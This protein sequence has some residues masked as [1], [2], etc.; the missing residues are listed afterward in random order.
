MELPISGNQTIQI[1]GNFQFPEN[2]NALFGLVILDP[3]STSPGLA[4]HQAPAADALGALVQVWYCSC[5]MGMLHKMWE[6]DES[7]SLNP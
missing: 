2:P 4:L 6:V 5:G 1:Y 7:L 3:S